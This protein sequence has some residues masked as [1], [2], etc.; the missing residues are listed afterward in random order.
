MVRTLFSRLPDITA[1]D[2]A[3]ALVGRRFGRTRMP[4]GRSLE[5]S[6]A[7]VVAGAAVAW[8][9][10][11]IWHPELDSARGLMVAGAAA[12]LG[13][14]GEL[15]SGRVDDNFSIPLAA[16]AGAAGALALVTP[17]VHG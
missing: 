7:F 3:A 11:G 14:V 4:N 13:A 15:A 2:P 8:G 5:G 17:A 10:L 6:A 16:A 12:V 9:T 1:A